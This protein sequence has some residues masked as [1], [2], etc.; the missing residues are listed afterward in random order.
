LRKPAYAR[1]VFI[2]CPFSVDYAPM[3]RALMFTVLDCGF[4]PRCGLEVRDG[5]EVRLQKIERLIEESMLGI[6]DISMMD[7]D[8]NT[9]LPRFN[10]P[11][12]LGMFLGAKR[13]GDRRQKR[14]KSLIL[15][16][17]PHRFRKSLSDIA[18]QDV[19]S[20][21]GQVA[22]AVRCVRTFLNHATERDLPSAPHIIERHQGY[23]EDLPAICKQLGLDSSELDYKDLWTTM[24]EWQK[25]RSGL[26]Y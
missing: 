3:F 21:D 13:F 9:E 22:D 26:A 12:E 20:H 7:L 24:I 5:G 10:M 25:A 6:H 17:S 1:S 16:S 15:D 19:E 18:G 8:Q 23:D 2:N 11:F 4:A 14:K